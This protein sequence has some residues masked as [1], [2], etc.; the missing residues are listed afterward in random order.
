MCVVSM[1]MMMTVVTMVM[2]VVTMVMML[3]T[4]VMTVTTAMGVV[5]TMVMVSAP[6]MVKYKYPHQV[7]DKTH[8]GYYEKSIVFYLRWFKGSLDS[9]REDEKGNKEQKQS[10]DKTSYNF[11]SN[12][13]IRE[14]FIGPPSCYHRGN[15]ASQ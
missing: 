11:S 9:F 12:V 2:L 15:Q 5:V 4:M 10:I 3:M 8:N 6:T 14:P 13:P 7:H 1:M